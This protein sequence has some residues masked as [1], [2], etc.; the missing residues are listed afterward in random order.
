MLMHAITAE[1][2]LRI[3]QILLVRDAILIILQLYYII[4]R[5]HVVLLSSIVCHIQ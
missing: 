4:D 3:F 1:N 2:C 5:A